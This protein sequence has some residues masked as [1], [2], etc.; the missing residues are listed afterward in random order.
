MF[1]ES[2]ENR[3][4]LICFLFGFDFVCNFLRIVGPRETNI[5]NNPE[6]KTKASLQTIGT[7]RNGIMMSQMLNEI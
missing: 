3:N 6:I 2:S 1:G 7:P 4:S 5:R